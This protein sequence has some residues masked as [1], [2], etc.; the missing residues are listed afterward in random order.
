MGGEQVARLAPPT[1]ALTAVEPACQ[2][3]EVSAARPWIAVGVHRDVGCPVGPPGELAHHV[4]VAAQPLPAGEP[5]AAGDHQLC[6]CE[7]ET[8]RGGGAGAVERARV[9]LAYECEDLWIA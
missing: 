7:G 8:V 5:V 4:D 6:R 2:G 9:E 1:S 3:E